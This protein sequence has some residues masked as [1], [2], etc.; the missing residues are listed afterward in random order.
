MTHTEIGS[1]VDISVS[2][3][4]GHEF[5]L[6]RDLASDLLQG[7][8][9]DYL[10]FFYSSGSVSASQTYSQYILLV[11]DLTIDQ[12]NYF[13][14]SDCR[15]YQIYIVVDSSASSESD[16]DFS[17][18]TVDLDTSPLSRFSGSGSVSS[19][20]LR[21]YTSYYTYTRE[22]VRVSS[23]VPTVFYS[24][25]DFHPHLV[26]GGVYIGAVQT[27]ILCAVVAFSL[28]DRIFKRIY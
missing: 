28:I 2:A 17:G 13:V 24:S 8:Y 5:E 7:C 14:S 20:D 15:V 6:A 25:L 4:S 21:Y 27:V 18:V 10:F 9:D 1:L 22:I 16:L 12:Q 3:V 19:P 26:Q 11:G 23:Q